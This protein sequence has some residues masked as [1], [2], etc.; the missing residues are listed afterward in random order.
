M[1]ACE[2]SFDSL[3][4]FTRYLL[5][6]RAL[7]PSQLCLLACSNPLFF[8]HILVLPLIVVSAPL[9]CS[10]LC[11]VLHFSATVLIK[12]SALWWNALINNWKTSDEED[13]RYMLNMRGARRSKRSKQHREKRFG[14]SSCETWRHSKVSY[15]REMRRLQKLSYS[16]INFAKAQIW[17]LFVLSSLCSALQHDFRAARPSLFLSRFVDI[18]LFKIYVKFVRA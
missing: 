8:S 4:S 2:N 9:R 10:V 14:V 18:C 12:I 3:C 13:G 7:L 6:I 16:I 1:R 11:C 17:F 15:S 5:Y